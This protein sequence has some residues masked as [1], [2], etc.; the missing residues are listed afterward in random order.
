VSGVFHID[1]PDE[2]LAQ[3]Q[4]IGTLQAMSLPGGIVVLR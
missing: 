2:V 4:R 1:R 3:V